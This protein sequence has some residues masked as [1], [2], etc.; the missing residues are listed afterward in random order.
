SLAHASAAALARMDGPAQSPDAMV[1]VVAG[2]LSMVH[3]DAPGEG[4]MLPALGAEAGRDSKAQIPVTAHIRAILERLQRHFPWPSKAHARRDSMRMLSA[5]VGAQVLARATS[6][7]A[8]A[9]ELLEA[10]R[11]EYIK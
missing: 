9:A 3:R 8:L 7:S 1:A 2:Y 5:M 6:D 11:S 4:C 10:V